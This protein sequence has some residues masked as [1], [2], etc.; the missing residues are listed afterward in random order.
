LLFTRVAKLPA[1]EYAIN[2]ARSESTG[3]APFFLNSRRMPRSMLWSS[4]PSN[5]FPSVRDFAL[6]RK[7][8]IMA[9]HDSILSARIIQTRDANRKRRTA[10]FKAGELVY[11]SSKNI[12]FAKGIAR[13]LIPKFIGPYKILQ[14]FGNSSF[15]L[16]LPPHL[17]QRGVHD[18]FHSSLLREHIP[19]DDR[20]FPGRMDNSLPNFTFFGLV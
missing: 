19:N 18:V 16:D 11:L 20:L 13:K 1:I 3:F 7:L 14:D 12:S 17:K 4:T 5:E 8:A 2:S 15:K 10:P 9:A 6:S